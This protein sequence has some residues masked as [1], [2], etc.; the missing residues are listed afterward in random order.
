MCS[1]SLS[2]LWFPCQLK[3][4]QTH[5]NK[6]NSFTHSS[7]CWLLNCNIIW[8]SSYRPQSNCLLPS[9]NLSTLSP[10]SPPH[11]PSFHLFSLIAIVIHFKVI[12][13]CYFILL[14]YLMIFLSLFWLLS[15]LSSAVIFIALLIRL[16]LL[17]VS[18]Y[19]IS[20]HHHRHVIMSSSSSCHHWLVSLLVCSFMS[21]S[22][23]LSLWLLHYY[24]CIVS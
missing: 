2:L 7:D 24:F 12:S 6:L 16:K 17:L 18:R 4:P 9:P 8:I 20:L 10:L 5:S 15:L 11:H 14:F 22:L 1:F 13:W 21:L 3:Q 19:I 23:S